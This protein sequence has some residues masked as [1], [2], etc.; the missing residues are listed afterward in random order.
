MNKRRYSKILLAAA[1]LYTLLSVM[2]FWNNH[3]MFFQSYGYDL[4]CDQVW[5]TLYLGLITI[6]GLGYL[7]LAA[8]P[9]QNRLVALMDA[10]GKV[11]VFSVFLIF[12]HRALLHPVLPGRLFSISYWQSCS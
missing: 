4:T 2:M 10:L 6:F 7:M 8:N 11:Y 9:L 5:T 12:N 1:G 3:E